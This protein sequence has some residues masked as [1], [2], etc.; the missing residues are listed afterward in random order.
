MF[1]VKPDI[2]LLQPFQYQTQSTGDFFPFASVKLV[3]VLISLKFKEGEMVNF[4][5]TKQQ[6]YAEGI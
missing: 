6:R 2:T 5:Q 4:K 1:L 3:Q